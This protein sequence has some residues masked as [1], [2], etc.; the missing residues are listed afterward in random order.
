MIGRTSCFLLAVLGATLPLSAEDDI[1]LL[2][3]GGT[4]I[5]MEPGEPEPVEGW[6]AVG[7]DGRVL[8][9]GNGEP[10]ADL[11]PAETL[12]ATGKIIMPGFISAHSHL[13]SAPFRGIASESNLY[14]WIATAHSPFREYY[15]EG[16]FLTYTQY[17]ALDFISHGITTCYNWVANMGHAYDLW[18]EQ[19][20]GQLSMPQRFVFGWAID[21]E[22]S[23][24]V[25]RERLEAFIARTNVLKAQEDHLLD[26]SLS[27]LGLLYGDSEIV[28]WEG[29]LMADYGLDAQTHYLEASEIKHRQHQEFSILQDAGFINEQ[30]HIAHFIHTNDYILDSAAEAGVR[31]AWNPL[32]NG[33]LG[34]GLADIPSIRQHGMEVGMGLDGQASGDLSDP[35]ENMRMGLYATRMKYED[36]GVMSPY[37]VLYLHTIGSAEML[38]VD[39]AVGSLEPGK[40]ADF[41]VLDPLEPDVAPIF[42]VYGTLV[43]AMSTRNLE[44]VYIGGDLTYADDAFTAIDFPAIREDA[45]RRVERMKGQ[46]EADGKPVPVPGYAES[47]HRP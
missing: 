6:M 7:A 34:S 31:M 42:D 33:R 39:D 41:L 4:I 25:N 5:T 47:Y 15:Q 11:E 38:G 17:G 2:V 9:I 29:R 14:E 37:Q 26:I 10:P 21:T 36:A 12:D 32:S 18:M 22:S 30:L 19:F 3:S 44:S 28:F 20:E 27:A 46:L 1:A 8:A 35:F 16:D 43:L 24:S 13:W 45:Y 40:F 23:E